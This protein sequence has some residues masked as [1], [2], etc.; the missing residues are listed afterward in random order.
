[1]KTL[2]SKTKIVLIVLLAVLIAGVTLFG[3]MGLN[4]TQTFGESYEVQISTQIDFTDHA[5]TI[6]ETAEKVL[7]KHGVKTADY[8][9]TQEYGSVSIFLFK[10]K[11]PEEVINELKTEVTAA[12]TT[13]KV[14]MDVEVTQYEANVVK[15]NSVRW[16]L[17]VGTLG[18][19]LAFGVYLMF[20]Q[21]FAAAFSVMVATALEGGLFLAL[22]SVS[23]IPVNTSFYAVML[24]S[25]ALTALLSAIYTGKAREY[26]KKRAELEKA[27]AEEVSEKLEKTNELSIA[28]FSIAMLLFAVAF[29]A[30]GP[31][32]MRWTGLLLVVATIS[33]DLAV[34]FVLPFFWLLFRKV[35]DKKRNKFAYKPTESVSG[36]NK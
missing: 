31:A 33:V 27:S 17:I 23:R 16:Q 24:A 4:K 5:D 22:A 11:L 14:P 28:V 7:K 3:V 15:D 2:M 25:V 19:I 35:T 6:K 30:I 34:L 9:L 1:M 18:A 36:E 21:R 10:N 20:R 26:T 13:D 32:L 8:S 12:I 29:L